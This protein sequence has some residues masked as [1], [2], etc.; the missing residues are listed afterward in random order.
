MYK[1]YKINQLDVHNSIISIL[2]LEFLV[3]KRV[4]LHIID[5]FF[6]YIYI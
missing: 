4:S 1:M 6:S 5:F 3:E 2:N